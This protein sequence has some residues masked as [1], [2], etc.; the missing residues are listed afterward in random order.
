MPEVSYARIVTYQKLSRK[1][2]KVNGYLDFTDLLERCNGPKHVVRNAE[3]AFIDEAQDLTPLQWQVCFQLFKNA[4]T[5][6]I[7]G[8]A[9]QCL[10][11]F[12]GADPK[13]FVHMQGNVHF[14]S[15]SYRLPSEVLNVAQRIL[16]QIP[17]QSKVNHEWEPAYIGGTVKHIVSLNEL[18]PLPDG[19][20]MLMLARNRMFLKRYVEWCQERGYPYYQGDRKSPIFTKADLIAYREGRV[21]DWDEERLEFAKQCEENGTL[22]TE[23]RILISTIYG[24]KGDEAD[25]VCLMTDMGKEV[26]KAYSMRHGEE[27]EHRCF[28]VGV[29]RSKETLYIVE[30]RTSRYYT[31]LL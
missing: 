14:L 16:D 23:P 30:P 4:K 12:T 29:T 9:N 19:K 27:E 3:V 17:P 1:F 8:D 24:V 31:H 10:Y 6:Y 20:T 28:F 25:I 18:P 2:R 15:R 26:Y 11:S 7:A 5:L 22:F 21:Q 13:V